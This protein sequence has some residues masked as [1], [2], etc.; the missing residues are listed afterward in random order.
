M[1]TLNLIWIYETILAYFDGINIVEPD[2]V[3]TF[4]LRKT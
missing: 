2:V 4:I 3:I 1:F